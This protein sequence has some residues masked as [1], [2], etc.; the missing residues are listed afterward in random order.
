MSRKRPMLA[1][2]TLRGLMAS[3]KRQPPSMAALP[4]D[5]HPPL[6]PVERNK[7][8]GADIAVGPAQHG[9]EKASSRS[10]ALGNI[11]RHLKSKSQPGAVNFCPGSSILKT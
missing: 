7:K 8:G 10:L 2:F 3:G 6:D 9:G 11:Q 4:G 1:R 5:S